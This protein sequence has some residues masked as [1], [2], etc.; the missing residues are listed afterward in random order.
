MPAADHNTLVVTQFGNRADA[1]V[2]SSVHAQ[3]EDLADIVALVAGHPGAR[4][5]DLGCG[6]GHVS[7]AVAP[8]VAEVVAYDLSAEMLAAVSAEAASRGLANVTAQRGPAEALPFADASFDFAITR[9]SAHHWYDMEAGLAQARRVL[10]PGGTAAFVDVVAPADAALDTFLQTVELLRDPSHVRDYTV[11]QWRHALDRAGFVVGRTTRR[12]LPL[13]YASW[14][15]RMQTPQ[16]LS[17]AIRALHAIASAQVA[18]Y[19]ELAPDGS[20]VI[21]TVAIEATPRPPSP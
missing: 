20:F 16:V 3:G 15:A 14:I 4:V 11:E 12:R 5:L 2:T 17:S 7:F 8:H 13:E 19:F 18:S 6:G 1:Y 21:D 9:F 10:K